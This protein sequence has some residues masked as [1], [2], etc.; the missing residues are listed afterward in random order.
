MPAGPVRAQLSLPKLEVMDWMLKAVA[1]WRL[2]E[3][4]VVGQGTDQQSEGANRHL[5]SLCTLCANYLGERKGM[6]LPVNVP[7]VRLMYTFELLNRWKTSSLLA[8][9][10]L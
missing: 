1:A 10:N 4:N 9:E 3:R 5:F 8:G 2:V 7:Y 6:L